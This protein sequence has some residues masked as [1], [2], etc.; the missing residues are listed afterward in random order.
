MSLKLYRINTMI[1]H[2]D[3][4]AGFYKDD[5][6][7]YDFFKLN[8]GDEEKILRR[9]LSFVA[10]K[11]YTLKNIN[12]TDYISCPTALLFS[13]RFVNVLGNQLEQ[14]MQFVPCN[15]ICENN[16]IKW[17]AARIKKRVSV[18]DEEASI[19]RK[20]TDGQKIIKFA[21]YRKDITIPFFIAEDLKYTSYY[22]VSELFKE[23][24]ENNNIL[25]KF[26]K[27]EIF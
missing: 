3:S 18:I 9:D 4:M 7:V 21:R 2:P 17:Y 10:G 27:P 5:K 6:D 22:V 8:K 16:N 20:L 13:E 24:C 11:G 14:D 1:N 15:L 19:Y 26:E 25:I 23:L 12:D